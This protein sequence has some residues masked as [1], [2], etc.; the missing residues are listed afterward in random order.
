MVAVLCGFG[1]GH[2]TES[3]NIVLMMK[4]QAAT[5][6]TPHHGLLL[7]NYKTHKQF[8]TRSPGPGWDTWLA[9]QVLGSVKRTM[10]GVN[11]KPPA[12]TEGHNACDRRSRRGV[13][14]VHLERQAYT[15]SKQNSNSTA[16]TTKQEAK[17]KPLRSR[18]R[19]RWK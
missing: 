16:R 8:S 14:G 15:A 2:L 18:P 12:R 13:G 19:K 11:S 7:S 17:L 10:Q 5:S 3:L 6:R 1:N 4:V 9:N